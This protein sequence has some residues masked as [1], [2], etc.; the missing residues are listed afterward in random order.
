M[1]KMTK[2]SATTW[3][4]FIL[5]STIGAVAFLTPVQ[6]D[7][8]T[9]IPMALMSDWLT[10][11]LESELSR[12]VVIV[13]SISQLIYMTEVGV[14]ILKSSIPLTF[15]KLLQIFLLCT[16]ISLPIAIIAGHAL[17]N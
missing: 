14:L 7:G 9:T 16:A 1:E 5:P 10:T 13:V 8:I 15:T 12:F 17:L 3:L 11:A 2:A 4:K 6:H